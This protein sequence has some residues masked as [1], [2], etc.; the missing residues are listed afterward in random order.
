[1]RARIALV[2]LAVLA[3]VVF[4][5]GLPDDLAPV[6]GAAA[7]CGD[8]GPGEACYCPDHVPIVNKPLPV[9]C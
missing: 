6:Q 2:A 8:G 1:M 9:N 5:P 4:V 7:I 3:L